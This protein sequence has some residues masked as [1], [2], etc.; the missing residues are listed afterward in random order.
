MWLFRSQMLLF[1]APAL[2]L[3]AGAYARLAIN[4]LARVPDFFKSAY[5]LSV[6]AAA[7]VA[8]APAV[9]S[10]C[11]INVAVLPFVDS[12]VAG[13]LAPKKALSDILNSFGERQANPKLG[14]CP[15]KS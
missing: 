1:D 9:V 12:D 4:H 2:A 15:V 8:A 7:A 6:L 11:P 13:F 5:G 10:G 3:P 14:A